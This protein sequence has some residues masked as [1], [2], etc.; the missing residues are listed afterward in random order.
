MPCSVTA[1]LQSQL[2]SVDLPIGNQFRQLRMAV[3]RQQLDGV[4]RHGGTTCSPTEETVGDGEERIGLVG[5][6][7]DNV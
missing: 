7:V 2:S 5:R 6:M 1:L 3:A 4:G